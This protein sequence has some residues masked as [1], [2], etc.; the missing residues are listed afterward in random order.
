M[1]PWQNHHLTSETAENRP[2][3][4]PAK[5][6]KHT[7]CTCIFICTKAPNMR[8]SRHFFTTKES[9]RNLL[10][11]I[12]L[13]IFAIAPTGK[14]LRRFFFK[15]HISSKK[16]KP[17]MRFFLRKPTTTP[18]ITG[19]PPTTS[20]FWTFSAGFV[21]QLLQIRPGKPGDPLHF[22]EKTRPVLCCFLMLASY[23]LGSTCNC[24]LTWTF[25]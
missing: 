14:P 6:M 22:G 17:L 19:T 4:K 15:K 12:S 11:K 8:L 25:I 1:K 13:I 7:N 20:Q 18:L 3:P 9:C 10:N 2:E 24:V 21:R 23:T 5:N 16:R